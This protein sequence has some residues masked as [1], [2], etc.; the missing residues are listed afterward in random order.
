VAAIPKR[1][2]EQMRVVGS[3]DEDHALRF[4]HRA[5]QCADLLLAESIDLVKQLAP[6]RL[7]VLE[8]QTVTRLQ[9]LNALEPPTAGLAVATRPRAC[10]SK[11]SRCIV[12]GRA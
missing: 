12:R 6:A 2:F 7:R 9:V 11:S 3:D 10:F 8:G 1:T 4:A 5:F